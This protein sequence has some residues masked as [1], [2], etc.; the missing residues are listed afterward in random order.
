MS[1][2]F[3]SSKIPKKNMKI[4][5]AMTKRLVI[6]WDCKANLLTLTAKKELKNITNPI[7]KLINNEASITAK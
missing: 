5:E 6:L 2:L 1:A 4:G 3:I 7:P